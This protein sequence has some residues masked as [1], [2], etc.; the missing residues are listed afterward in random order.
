LIQNVEIFI[1]IAHIAGVFVGFAALI[2]IIRRDEI[3]LFRLSRI[4]AVVTIGLLV[5]VGALIPI[6]FDLYGF[7]GHILWFICSLIFLALNWLMGIMSLLDPDNREMMIAQMRDNPL[8]SVLFWLLFEFPLQISLIL[9]LLGLFPDIEHALYT[10]ALFFNLFEAIFTLVQ[11][12]Y[13]Q[14]S[15]SKT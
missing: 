11:L 5:V 14:G 13:S 3:E 12:V 8:R 6:G 10:T 7:S 15:S 2:S 4:R 1:G 9:I